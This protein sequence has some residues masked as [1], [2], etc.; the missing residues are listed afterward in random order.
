[1]PILTI[2]IAIFSHLN[3]KFLFVVNIFFDIRDVAD[4]KKEMHLCCNKTAYM[5]ENLNFQNFILN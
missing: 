1:M 4:L 3:D 2:S 5:S